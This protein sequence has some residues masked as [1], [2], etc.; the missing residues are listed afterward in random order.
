MTWYRTDEEIT[1]QGETA[2]RAPAGDTHELGVLADAGILNVEIDGKA[3]LPLL[4]EG[5][6]TVR[7][8]GVASYG[9]TIGCEYDDLR[10]TTT[11]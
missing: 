9:D 4:D 8:A 5:L 3:V 6:G 1:Y 11:P 2:F 7:S 10:V